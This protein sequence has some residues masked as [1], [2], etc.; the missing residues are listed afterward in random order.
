MPATPVSGPPAAPP[1]PQRDSDS[2]RT[3]AARYSHEKGQNNQKERA[4]QETVNP[5]ERTTS[6]RR[7]LSPPVVSLFGGV[8]PDGLDAE[9]G[10]APVMSREE[11]MERE[12]AREEKGPDPWAVK[13]EPGEKINPKVSPP[14]EVG[15]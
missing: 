1:F 15:G 9:E 3:A 2:D 14:T 13:F 12:L 7:T 5:I 8:S 11:E 6:L 10:L 4:T